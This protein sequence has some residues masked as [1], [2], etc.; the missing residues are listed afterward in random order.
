M[1]FI[2]D[3]RGKLQF[4]LSNLGR[5]FISFQLH[6]DLISVNG[7]TELVAYSLG[8]LYHCSYLLQLLRFL[9][10]SEGPDDLPC[11]LVPLLIPHFSL[12]EIEALQ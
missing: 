10:W 6:E 5:L 9:A 3:T 7:D 8:A 12:L 1:I 11:D 2:S 4:P